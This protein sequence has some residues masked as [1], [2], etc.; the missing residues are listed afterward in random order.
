MAN[1]I[2]PSNSSLVNANASSKAK[3]RQTGAQGQPVEQTTS[4]RNDDAVSV[5]RAAEVLNAAPSERG[6]G[7]IQTA[8]QASE[9]AKHIRSLF[10]NNSG[11]ALAAQAKN[12]SGEMSGLL[13]RA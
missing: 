12:V 13:A 10:E 5:S 11:L 9:L 3:E 2:N 4:Q 6:E 7:R 1:P 8:D